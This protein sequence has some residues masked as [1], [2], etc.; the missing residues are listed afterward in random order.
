LSVARA[1]GVEHRVVRSPGGDFDVNQLLQMP[2]AS[3][4]PRLRHG[5]GAE[6]TLLER[7]DDG[8]APLWLYG[9]GHVGQ[10][11][12]RILAELPVSVTWVDSRTGQFPAQV[13]G[14]VQIVTSDDPAQSVAGAPAGTRFLVM[15]HSHALDYAICR[16]ILG[17][18]DFLWAGLIGSQSKAARF[19]SR[20]LR[21]G[22]A[23]EA[24]ARLVCPIGIAGISSK[25]PAAIAVGVAAQI[26]QNLSADTEIRDPLALDGGLAQARQVRRSAP[27]EDASAAPAPCAGCGAHTLADCVSPRSAW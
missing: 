4:S 5:P 10:A 9:A 11:L 1:S 20:W 22:I 3:A 6:S 12:V 26:L 23:P 25:W 2:R 16:A 17:R 21:D 13:E 18:G 19:K 24:I 14:S 7:L 8:L 27:C 15:T